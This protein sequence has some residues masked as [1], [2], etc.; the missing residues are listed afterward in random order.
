MANTVTVTQSEVVAANTDLWTE[1]MHLG[2]ISAFSLHV[3]VIGTGATL[4]VQGSMDGVNWLTACM[5]RE[6]ASP[7]NYISHGTLY[8]TNCLFRY[9][10]LRMTSAQ[11]T[12]TTTAVLTKYSRDELETM[13]QARFS[14]VTN[15]A[16][17]TSP[18]MYVQPYN[19][20]R[21]DI[22]S[23][24]ITSTS[25]STAI[26]IT[27]NGDTGVICVSNSSV[28]GTSP[29]MDVVV[30]E[31]PDSGTHWIDI[32]HFQRMTTNGAW[33]SPLLRFNGNRLRYVRTISGTSPTFTCAVRRINHALA[34][35]TPCRRRF[36][37]SIVFNTLNSVTQALE[38]GEWG[39]G[40][41]VTVVMG[42]A[43]TAP[44]L[45]IEASEDNSNW[46]QIGTDLTPVA[47]TTVSQLITGTC[48][49][50]VRVR[51]KTAGVSAVT[52]YVSIRST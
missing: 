1:D 46:F 50:F 42:T 21:D 14:V 37:R 35:G 23:A 28:G 4:A 8:F 29:A 19:V 12:G 27:H 38:T 22:A 40:I 13:G 6:S 43:T 33:T 34:M 36:D 24:D 25:T 41:R 26:D 31:S 2:K 39:D 11:T 52:G 20:I 15:S 49:P 51:V 3:V 10:R 47:S 45:A 16:S 44:V 9:Y 17:S 30:Q 7:V 32:Y 5:D 48:P 18:G